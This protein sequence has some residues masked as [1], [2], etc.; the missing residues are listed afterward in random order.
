MPSP[1]WAAAAISVSFFWTLAIST[2]LY[3]L[4][5]DLFGARHAGFSVAIL[6]SSFGLMTALVSPWIG[7]MIDQA[8]FTPVCVVLSVMPLAGVAVLKLAAR[9]V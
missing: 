2:N 1:G 3:A 6:T 4:P 9:R 5:L 8:G 7:R